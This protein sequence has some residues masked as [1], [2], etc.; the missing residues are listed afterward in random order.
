MGIKRGDNDNYILIIG[1]KKS[2]PVI[3]NVILKGDEANCFLVSLCF[4]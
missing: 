2:W 1:D 4:Y 3:L